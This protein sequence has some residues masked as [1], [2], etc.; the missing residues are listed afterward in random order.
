MRQDPSSILV[1]DDEREMRQL[2]KDTLEE[3]HYRVVVASDGKEALTRM[4]S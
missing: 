3:D 1:V 2:L 4:E